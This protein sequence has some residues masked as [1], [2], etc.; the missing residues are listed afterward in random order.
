MSIVDRELSPSLG[1]FEPVASIDRSWL[2]Q[3]DHFVDIDV[4]YWETDGLKHVNHVVVPAYLEHGLLKLLTSIGDPEPYATIPF[5]HVTAELLVRYVRPNFF[6]E[7]LCV[8][9]R[10][11]R[12]GNKSATIE[13][14][15]LGQTGEVRVVGRTVIVRTVDG[16]SVPWTRAQRAAL[17]SPSTIVA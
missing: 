17:A 8:G 4:R 11:E 10:V 7:V 5:S 16:A 2:A 14:V 6:G 3:F 12:I 9:S 13:Q 15:V 1:R